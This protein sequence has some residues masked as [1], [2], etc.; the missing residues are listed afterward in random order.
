M[1]PALKLVVEVDGWTYHRSRRRWSAIAPRHRRLLVAGY[2]VLRI[3]WR[4]LTRDPARVTAMLGALLS[5]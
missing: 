4:Q 3:T 5:R 2:R 1:W